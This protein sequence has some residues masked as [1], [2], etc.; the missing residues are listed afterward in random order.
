M[1]AAISYPPLPILE[2][3][4]INL[5]AHGLL[6]GVGFAAGAWVM[7]REVRARG[8]DVEKYWSVLAWA[9]VGAI[10]GARLF[11]IPAHLGDPGYDFGAAISLAGFFSILGGFAG[12]I[13]VG[14]YRIWRLGLSFF[15]SA[16]MAALGLA[17][18]T[19]VG[20]IGDLLIVEHL[21]SAT[22]FFL[23]YAVKPGYDLAPQHN[24]LEC[25][26]A[27]AIDG[28][29]GI[30]HHTGLYDLVGAL[31]LLGVLLWL[32]RYWT[33]RHYG[34]LF[35]VWVIWYGLQRFLIDFTRQGVENADRTLGALTWTQWSGLG[36]A[37]LGL[38]MLIWLRSRFPVVSAEQDL[39]Y[40]AKPAQASAEG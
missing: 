28:I 20:R 10:I 8:F 38:A 22:T 27:E 32:R 34:Q 31:V 35:S 19:I 15:P 26:S 17:I 5:S 18:G 12:G 33:T 4:P 36:S 25:T 11:T 39:V 40:G 1:L 2:L 21:G 13:I 23:G 30:Y 14:G 6:A 24:V 29:C 16:D 3:G 9:L 37:V 7:I